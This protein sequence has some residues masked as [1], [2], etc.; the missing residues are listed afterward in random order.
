MNSNLTSNVNSKSIVLYDSESNIYELKKIIKNS[1][2]LIITFN[3]NSHNFLL[4]NKIKHELSDDYLNENDLDDIQDN[5]YKFSKWYS[6]TKISQLVEYDVINI[7]ELFYVEFCYFL[8]PILK[9]FY[10]IMRISSKFKSSTFISSKSLSNLIKL[11]S[12]QVKNL[13]TNYETTKSYN[14]SE[15]FKN[16]IINQ[17]SKNMFHLF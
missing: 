3:L 11:F 6:D 17:L 4:K 9:K 2:P 15:V 14:N 5:S 10:E 8:T 12:N 1:N 7:G 16:S 13:D